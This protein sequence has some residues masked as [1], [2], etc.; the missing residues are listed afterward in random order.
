M[1]AVVEARSKA[2]S[3]NIDASNLDAQSLQRFQEAQSGLTQALSRLIMLQESYPNLKANENF[4][5]LQ[6]QLEGT[7]NRITVERQ[8]FND[9]TRQYNTYIK[10]FPKNLIAM[11]FSFEQKPYFQAE[12][13]SEKAPKVEF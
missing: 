8:K 7:E 10:K 3:V 4:R 5:D 13:G 6:A 9:V 1:T 11:M 12:E 2:T